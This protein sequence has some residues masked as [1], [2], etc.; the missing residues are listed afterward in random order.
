MPGAN[1]AGIEVPEPDTTFGSTCYF[2]GALETGQNQ[3]R[4]RARA[5]EPLKSRPKV[6]ERVV[7]LFDTQQFMGGAQ[8][9]EAPV[10]EGTTEAK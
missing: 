4:E 10:S 1:E 2:P 3:A 6:R 8:K 5:P 7:D 9:Q